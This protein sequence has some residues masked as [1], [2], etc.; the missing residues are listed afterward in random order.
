[1]EP[2]CEILGI[3]VNEL[4]A[5]EH[6]NLSELLCKLD[7]SRLELV[8]ELEFAQLKF[9]ILKLYGFEITGM[10]VSDNGAGSLTYFVETTEEKYVVKYA[11][12]NEMNHPELEPKLCQHLRK[13]GI[14]AS[15]FIKNLHGGFISVDENGRRFHIQKFIDGV[16]YSY[17]EAPDFLLKEAPALLAKIHKVLKDFEPL[18]EGIGENFFRYRTP[19]TVSYTHLTLPTMAVV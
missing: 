10:E 8:K 19:E 11:S 14:P 15:E 16:T 2:L 17:N 7:M 1:M 6:L 18:P 3:T 5:G 4:L 9:R 13:Y 12:D